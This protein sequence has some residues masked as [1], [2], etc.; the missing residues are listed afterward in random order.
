MFSFFKKNNTSVTLLPVTVDMH[1][2]ILPGIDDGSPDVETSVMLVKG[3]Y[4]L[5]IR[6]CIATPHIIGDLYRN[7]DET[8]EA[9]LSK[10]QKACDE[11]AI[12]MKL[13]AAAEYM[14]DD[15]FMELLQQQ[16]PLRTLHKN[17]LLTEIPYTAEPVNL[18]EIV[19]NIITS[20]YQPVLAHPERYF[21]FH[22]NYKGYKKLK[23]LGFLLQ[24]NLLS[25]T[26]YYGKEVAR[27]AR[28]LLDEGLVDLAG[29]D[30]HHSRHL[31]TFRA[32]KH[33]A[34]LCKYIRNGK[35]LNS[36]LQD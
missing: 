27:A 36:T 26:G 20:G 13:S 15:Y 10:L 33:L 24:V 1:S 8:I 35:L 18:Q 29:T 3:L 30:L 31:N 16:K 6:K 17:I 4:D 21:Y 23:E 25:L 32:Q 19:F 9:A 11:A 7:N 28:Y 14:L 2:H 34:L 22:Q 5:G 12:P